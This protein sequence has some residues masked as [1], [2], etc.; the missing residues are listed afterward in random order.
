MK[1][2]LSMVLFLNFFSTVAESATY[3]CE[4]HPEVKASDYRFDVI[5]IKKGDRIE[6]GSVESLDLSVYN[7]KVVLLSVFQT[8]CIF[9]AL[10]L[11]FH[12]FLQKY[13]WPE[14]HVVMVNLGI[15]DT[16]EETLSFVEEDHK[17]TQYGPNINLKNADFYLVVNPHGEEQKTSIETTGEMVSPDTQALLFPGLAGT[18][19][20]VILDQDGKVR[21]RGHF[22]KDNHYKFITSLVHQSCLPF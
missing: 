6:I 22:T 4:P 2:L 12:S 16:A 7:G 1:K 20:S 14:D 11:F 17:K 19:Y 13:I 10:D 5:P 18:P 15:G 21:F 3:S 9:C 8:K